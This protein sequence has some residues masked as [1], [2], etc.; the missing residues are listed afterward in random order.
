[1]KNSSTQNYPTSQHISNGN[2]WAWWWGGG[3]GCTGDIMQGGPVKFCSE[4]SILSERLHRLILLLRS[5]TKLRHLRGMRLSCRGLLRF[6]FGPW[7]GHSDSL[8]ELSS[9]LRA[10]LPARGHLPQQYWTTFWSLF[11]TCFVCC[12]V[13]FFNFHI[14]YNICFW[15]PGFENF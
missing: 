1:M 8:E 14:L 12:L 10:G 4:C 13:F 7:I 9:T 15:V 2:P 11:N 3:G 6:V 5:R